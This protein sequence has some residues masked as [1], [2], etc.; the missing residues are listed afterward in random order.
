MDQKLLSKTRTKKNMKKKTTSKRKTKKSSAC[1]GLS[2]KDCVFPCKTV[3]KRGNMKT[4]GHCKTIFSKHRKYIDKKTGKIVNGHMRTLRKAAK[5]AD[6]NREASEFN[7]KKSK[8]YAKKAVQKEKEA[9]KKESESNSILSNISELLGI[10]ASK[11]ELNKQ[12]EVEIQEPFT[13]SQSEKPIPVE[14]IP[15]EPIPVEP[16]PVEPIPE[17]PIPEEPIPEEPIPEEPNEIVN[18][19]PII[20]P[21]AEEQNREESEQ[22]KPMQPE[23]NIIKPQQI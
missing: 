4:F 13:E 8:Q 20:E 21:V 10:S 22:D 18:P 5:E 6:K 7:E 2:L 9:E 14:P 3:K 1:V 16:V 17:E 23:E 11:P 15:V 12:K 19:E